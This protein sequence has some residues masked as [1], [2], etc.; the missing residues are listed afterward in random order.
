MSRLSR[1]KGRSSTPASF[2]RRI[3]ENRLRL[4]VQDEMLN[5]VSGTRNSSN[6]I[7]E[8]LN[9]D[10]LQRHPCVRNEV[11]FAYSPRCGQ[12]IQF[13]SSVPSS[14]VTMAPSPICAKLDQL[15]A[16]TQHNAVHANCRRGR[17]PASAASISRSRAPPPPL[18]DA[19]GSVPGDSSCML[20]DRSHDLP[21]DYRW[22]T[23]PLAALPAPSEA[24]R[25]RNLS[26]GPSRT[27]AS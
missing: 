10:V 3:T 12:N 26:P 23:P 2:V 14:G 17:S 4:V 24:T 7:W 13:H 1:E 9:L 6:T 18:G 21:R 19:Y 20:S 5:P 22:P 16:S 11:V 25:T 27:P 8:E 15:G